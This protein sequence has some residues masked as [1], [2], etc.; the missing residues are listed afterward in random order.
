[1]FLNSMVRCQNQTRWCTLGG[2]AAVCELLDGTRPR[3]LQ[4][5]QAIDS[6]DMGACCVTSA[7][8]SFEKRGG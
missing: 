4:Y 3:L 1:E 2:M 6:P 5:E 8:M 7:A